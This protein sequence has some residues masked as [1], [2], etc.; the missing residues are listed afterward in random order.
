M[1]L[2][3][4]VSTMHQN[5]HSILEKMNIQSDAIIINQCDRNEIEK[6]TFKGNSIN[7][8]SLLER[9]VGL[10]R[11]TALMRATADICLFA[12]DDVSYNSDYK[13]VIINEFLNNPKADMIIFNVPST[14]PERGRRL[15]TKNKKLNLHNCFRFG[16]YQ[17]AVRLASI[18]SANIYFSLLFGGGAKYSA[19]EDSLF[20]ADC[21]KK[22]LKVYS[23]VKSIGTVSHQES[24]WFKGYTDKYFV[25]KGV[26][27][28]YLSKRWAK[29]L[30]LRFSIRHRELFKD[31]KTWYEAFRLM[32]KGIEEVNR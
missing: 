22:G 20:I 10:S 31:S 11:N 21:M 8:L 6:F 9:G 26:F 18:R 14:H 4:L 27:Y 25:D 29:V 3:V 23:S 13:E 28:A 2:Q 32:S 17:I 24:T 30:S 12:D 5:D 15:I 1:N 7:F 16:T 19:G